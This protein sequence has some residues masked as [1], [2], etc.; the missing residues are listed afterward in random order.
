[1]STGTKPNAPAATAA[2]SVGRAPAA[3]QRVLFGAPALTTTPRANF[4]LAGF[5]AATLA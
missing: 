3:P 5:L 2:G 1:M 4:R